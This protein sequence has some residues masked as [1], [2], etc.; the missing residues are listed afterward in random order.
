MTIPRPLITS[1]FR[2]CSQ[3]LFP[4]RFVSAHCTAKTCLLGYELSQ[5]SLEGVPAGVGTYFSVLCDWK[6]WE[7]VL[8]LIASPEQ[9]L[10]G[11]RKWASS[12]VELCTF[13]Q[14]SGNVRK[15]WRWHPHIEKHMFRAPQLGSWSNLKTIHEVGAGVW[16][17]ESQ[18]P[19]WMKENSQAGRYPCIMRKQ[20]KKHF[21][22]K[23]SQ[24]SLSSLQSKLASD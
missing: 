21:R 19:K 20:A 11:R 4:P 8:Q 9:G 6:P 16:Q 14:H 5:H 22:V 13:V 2:L 1:W 12:A 3:V 24:L 15:M 17:G 7:D 23:V 10:K 18:E